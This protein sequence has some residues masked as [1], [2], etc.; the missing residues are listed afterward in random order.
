MK[1]GNCL[2]KENAVDRVFAGPTKHSMEELKNNALLQVER[3]FW[4]MLKSG[5]LDAVKEIFSFFIPKKLYVVWKLIILTFQ[6]DSCS[7]IRNKPG[8]LRICPL[9][10]SERLHPLQ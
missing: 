7:V 5:K 10:C 8:R 4:H 1:L 9:P 2:T 3:N 6:C